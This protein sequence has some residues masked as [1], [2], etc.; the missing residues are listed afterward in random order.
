MEIFGEYWWV[1]EL[2]GLNWSQ[3]PKSPISP[4]PCPSRLSGISELT[5][6]SSTF[7]GGYGNIDT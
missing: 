2:G 7:M 1:N 4:N 5:E 6:N 3:L